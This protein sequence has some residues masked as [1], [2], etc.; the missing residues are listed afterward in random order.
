MLCLFVAEHNLSFSILDHLNNIIKRAISESLVIKKFLINRQKAQ[1]IITSILGPENTK[2]VSTFCNNNYFSIIIDESNDC[3]VSKN[4]SIVVR[5]F[6][7]K[8]RDRFLSLESISDPSAKGIVEK[9]LEVLETNKISLK[10]LIGFTADNC[11]VMMGQINGVQ[12]RLKKLVPNLFVNGCICH[13]LNLCSSSAYLCLPKDVEKFMKEISYYFCNSSSRK[14]ELN[15]FQEYF[16]ADVHTILRYS[17]TR[18]LSR[19]AVVERFLEQ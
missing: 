6:D 17:Q 4:L 16:G 11:N 2:M 5:T 1:N 18:W 12:A 13:I 3:T 9:I 8:C 19:Q 7:E 15:T 14:E 10:N